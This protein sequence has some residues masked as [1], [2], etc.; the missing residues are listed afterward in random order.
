MKVCSGVRASGYC[1]DCVV[2]L[3]HLAPTAVQIVCKYRQ[4]TCKS[5]DGTRIRALVMEKRGFCG[6]HTIVLKRH[7]RVFAE[8]VPSQERKTGVSGEA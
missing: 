3:R 2:A 5:R 6:V 7:R 4:D 8:C 1:E